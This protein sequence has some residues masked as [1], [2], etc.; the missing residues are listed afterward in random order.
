MSV[1]KSL[2]IR[3]LS[4]LANTYTFLARNQ[5]IG[6]TALGMNIVL[7]IQRGSAT[8]RPLLQ[9]LNV[10]GLGLSTGEPR[11]GSEPVDE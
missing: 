8:M 7:K 2:I 5:S 1:P 4:A 10:D 3:I 11:I 9:W 6:V